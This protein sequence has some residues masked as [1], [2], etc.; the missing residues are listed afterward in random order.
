MSPT[1][2]S[3][4]L[5]L[6]PFPWDQAQSFLLSSRTASAQPHQGFQLQ[7]KL[8]LSQGMLLSPQLQPW[9]S[10]GATAHPVSSISAKDLTSIYCKGDTGEEGNKMRL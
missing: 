2:L 9:G 3:R 10:V 5:L 8:W 7:D 1:Q 4:E 6:L